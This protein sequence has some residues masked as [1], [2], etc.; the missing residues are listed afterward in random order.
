MCYITKNDAHKQKN[1]TTAVYMYIIVRYSACMMAMDTI[2]YYRYL[3]VFSYLY[4]ITHKKTLLCNYY[5]NRAFKW[6]LIIIVRR[7]SL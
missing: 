3:Y 6:R 5:Y 1:N 2:L 4:N 7:N